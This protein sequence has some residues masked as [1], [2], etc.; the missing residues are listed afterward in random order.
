MIESSMIMFNYETAQSSP[1]DVVPGYAGWVNRTDTFLQPYNKA[2]DNAVDCAAGQQP[3]SGSFCRFDLASLGIPSAER[4]LAQYCS[5]NAAAEVN[6]W[7]FYLS[8]AFFRI[9]AILQGVYK[10]SLQSMIHT[11]F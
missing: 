7:N 11:D 3:E 4:Y 10:R 9:A 5:N 2:A 1:K 8:F 6:T